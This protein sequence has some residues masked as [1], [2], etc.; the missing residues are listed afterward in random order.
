MAGEPQPEVAGVGGD[1]RVVRQEPPER[2]DR[3]A[4]MDAGPVPGGLV[5]RGRRL[6]R[7]PILGVDGAPGV[8]TRGV[9]HGRLEPRDR[10]PEERPGVGAD[11][12]RGRLEARPRP[13]RLDVDLG[14]ALAGRRHGIA[15]GA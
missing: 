14:P 8:D 2:R 15:V 5:D 7:R 11:R 10:G 3:V 1:D 4:G 12:E 9:E 6:P 13:E